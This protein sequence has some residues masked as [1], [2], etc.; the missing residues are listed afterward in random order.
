MIKIIS[1]SKISLYSLT[2]TP[3]TWN[4]IHDKTHDWV[5]V[6][7]DHETYA[8]AFCLLIWACDIKTQTSIRTTI[9]FYFLF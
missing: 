7:F 8:C 2:F 6:Y 3:T 5:D 1:I 4:T 9:V